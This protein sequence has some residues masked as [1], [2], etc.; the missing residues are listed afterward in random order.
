VTRRIAV[1]GIGLVTAL[2][3]TRDAS[4]RGLLAG[5]CGIRAATVFATEGY[6]SR[7]AAEVDMSGVDAGTTP[8]ERRRRSRSDRI[9][10]R[11]ATEAIEDAGLLDNGIDRSRV[12]VSLGA[13]TADLLRNE[14]FYRTWITAGLPRTRRSDVWNHFRAHR[15]TSSPARSA[16]KGRA[17]A[18]R[19]RARRARSRLAAPLKRSARAADAML[20]GGTDALAA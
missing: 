9:G 17:P 15:S 3:A 1:T 10:V 16:S 7:V 19:R 18:W 11:A 8:L 2:G 5:D 6:R 12:G 14:D 13:G 4:W 20:A